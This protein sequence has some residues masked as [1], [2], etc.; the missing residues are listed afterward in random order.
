MKTLEELE[1][2]LSLAYLKRN[3]GAPEKSAIALAKEK[4]NIWI[5]AFPGLFNNGTSHFSQEE[6]VNPKVKRGDFNGKKSNKEKETKKDV[7]L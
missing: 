1:F 3:P 4:A 5:Q 6:V 7:K 2:E